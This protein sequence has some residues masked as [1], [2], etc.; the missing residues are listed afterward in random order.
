MYCTKPF[1]I[2]LILVL[3]RYASMVIKDEPESKNVH[4]AKWLH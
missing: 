3:I 4:L 1:I 2:F